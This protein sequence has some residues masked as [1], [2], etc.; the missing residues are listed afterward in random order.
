MA[1]V[2]S[3]VEDN[4]S[5]DQEGEGWFGADSRVL[6]LFALYFYYYYI[7]STKELQVLDPRGWGLLL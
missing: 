5:T 7:S 4:F 1:P 3:F 2:T 6:Y